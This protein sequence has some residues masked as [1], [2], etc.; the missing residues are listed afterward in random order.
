MFSDNSLSLMIITIQSLST[1]SFTAP[2][3]PSCIKVVEGSD[4][5]F[6]L[7]V[8]V[9]VCMFGNNVFILTQKNYSNLFTK[10]SYTSLSSEVMP[11][12]PSMSSASSQR[13]YSSA[14]IY[15]VSAVL[16]NPDML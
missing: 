14:L 15:L 7:M 10:V 8:F 12:E 5:A 2:H 1:S 11:V 3:S 4:I 16:I 9:E 13:Q 6:H